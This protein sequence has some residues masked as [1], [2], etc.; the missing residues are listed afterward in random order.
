M[1]SRASI[2]NSSI[3]ELNNI[4]EK[5]EKYSNRLKHYHVEI[6]NTIRYLK[7]LCRW[8]SSTPRYDKVIQVDPD[9]IRYALSPQYNWA[10]LSSDLTRLRDN[11]NQ[12]HNNLWDSLDYYMI[13]DGDWDEKRVKIEKCY[14]VRGLLEKYIQ[15]KEWQETSEYSWHRELGRSTEDIKQHFEQCERLY[16]SLQ[17]NGYKKDRPV[18]VCIGRNGEII[19]SE[20]FHRITLSKIL[21]INH[22]SARVRRRHEEW[23]KTRNKIDRT[24]SISDIDID[25][26]CTLDHPDLQDVI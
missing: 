11:Q 6:W 14:H 8:G 13:T 21:K 10:P 22:I 1:N 19:R 7:Y 4:R 12:S 5:Y 9:E 23:Q 3:F 2:Q 24:E 25:E 26:R 17:K 16:E 18:E 20:G 15:G